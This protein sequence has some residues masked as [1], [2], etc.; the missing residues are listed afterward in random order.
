MLAFVNTTF[1]FVFTVKV[2]LEVSLQPFASA[3]LTVYV[4]AVVPVVV[5]EDPVPFPLHAYV[6]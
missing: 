3:T 2:A 4:P 1:G 6:V 5:L